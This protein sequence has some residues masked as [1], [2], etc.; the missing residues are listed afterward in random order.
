MPKV[1]RVYYIVDDDD[2]YR[3]IETT[4]VV[5]KAVAEA[6]AGDLFLR[7]GNPM[8]YRKD[9]TDAIQAW[10]NEEH[11][12]LIAWSTGCDD[13]VGAMRTTSPNGPLNSS[14]C[15]WNFRPGFHKSRYFSTIKEINQAELTEGSVNP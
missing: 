8:M 1:G 3:T 6:A 7:L 15:H 5:T 4:V 2:E 10:Y 9:L 12:Q 13:T 11:I 14:A